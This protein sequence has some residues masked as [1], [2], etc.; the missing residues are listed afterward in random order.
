MFGITVDALA[1]A[2]ADA[3]FNIDLPGN[4]F[5]MNPIKHLEMIK[6]RIEI[7]QFK[8]TKQINRDVTKKR[9]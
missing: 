1:L 3:N 6:I 7:A 4:Y 8:V 2:I 5:G 9:K